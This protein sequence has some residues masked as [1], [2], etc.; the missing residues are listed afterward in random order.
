MAWLAYAGHAYRSLIIAFAVVATGSL[1]LFVRRKFVDAGTIDTAHPG[2]LLSLARHLR[3]SQTAV[4]IYPWSARVALPAV[5]L[6]A[7]V[8]GVLSWTYHISA[9]FISN[10]GYFCNSSQRQLDSADEVDRQFYFDTK[11]LCQNTGIGVTE[12]R[13]Y[14]VI[15]TIPDDDDWFDKAIWTDVRGIPTDRVNYYLALPLKRWWTKNWFQPVARVGRKGNFEYALEPQ[16]PLPDVPLRKCEAPAEPG[17]KISD[18]ASLATRQAVKYC[19]GRTLK[20]ARKLMAEF[21]PRASGELFMYVNDAVLLWPQKAG[22]FY[23]NNSGTARVVISPVLAPV[24]SHATLRSA[25]LS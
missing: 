22:I 4:K 11:S 21:T 10:A 14:R 7:C 19:A 8:V 9:A 13:R 16:E 25:T 12:G 20:P 18:P 24:T 5:F 6:A 1:T 17:A 23:N 15:M 3:R 2:L